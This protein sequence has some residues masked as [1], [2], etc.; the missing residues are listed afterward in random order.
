MAPKKVTKSESVEQVV[1]PVAPVTE[2]KSRSKKTEE[3]PVVAPVA[4][5]TEKKSRSKK[6][7]EKPATDAVSSEEDVEKK[8]RKVDK[9][10]VNTDFETVLTRIAEE[11]AKI[12]ASGDKVRGI[13]AWKTVNKLV[14]QLQHDTNKVTK[15]KTSTR[16]ANNTSGFLKPVKI[17]DEMAVFTNWDKNKTYSRTDV[18]RFICNYIKEKA[19]NDQNDKRNINCDA[20]LKKLLKYDPADPKLPKDEKTGK[21]LPL[22][23]FRL[24]QY[25]KHHFIKVETEELDQ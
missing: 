13:K 17:S 14:K 7:E 22:T 3:K 20:K 19:L 23:Y 5:A 9:D 15:F 25:L 11:V 1:A 16:K 21:T 4:P 2:K 10:T 6:T 12:K 18:T 24:Q 8:R